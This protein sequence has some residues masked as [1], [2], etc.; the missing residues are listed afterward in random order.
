MSDPTPTSNTSPTAP[1]SGLT[2]VAGS[3]GSGGSVAPLP[4]LGQVAGGTGPIGPAIAR[5]LVTAGLDGRRSV[6]VGLQ[7]SRSES[8]IEV[9]DQVHEP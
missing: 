8:R 6:W 2:A 1:Q 4:P 9:A 3:R 5:E 7:R